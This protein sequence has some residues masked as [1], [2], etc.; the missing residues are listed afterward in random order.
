MGMK[1]IT[2]VVVM[3]PDGSVVRKA[4]VKMSVLGINTKNTSQLRIGINVR[5]SV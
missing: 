3:L 5:I 4:N 1:T 2:V